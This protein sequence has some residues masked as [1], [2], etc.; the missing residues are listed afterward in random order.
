MSAI[1]VFIYVLSFGSYR[2]FLDNKISQLAWTESEVLSRS[3]S[4]FSRE[5]GHIKRVT[6]LLRNSVNAR[7]ISQQAPWNSKMVQ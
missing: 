3:A 2:Y 6:L 7:L 1:A 5:I 4:A